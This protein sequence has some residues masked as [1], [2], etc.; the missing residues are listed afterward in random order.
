V[1]GNSLLIADMAT[2]CWA[3]AYFWATVSVEGLDHLNTWFAHLDARPTTQAVLQ[4]PRHRG[5]GRRQCGALQDLMGNAMTET[6]QGP[7][8]SPIR[9]DIISDVVCPWCI[10]GFKQLEKAQAATGLP[11]VIYWHP[12]ELNPDMPAEGENLRDHI[13]RK[14]G[15]TEEQSSAARAQMK[16]LGETLGIAFKFKDDSRAK[17]LGSRLNLKMTVVL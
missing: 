3:R 17:H 11:V 1:V 15:S 10:I 14:Y 13:M 5:G 2:Y 12:F 9:I 8:R 4:L 16:S 6:E 7:D